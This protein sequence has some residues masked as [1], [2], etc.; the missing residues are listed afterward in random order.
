MINTPEIYTST[1]P[2]WA[3]H[4]ELVVHEPDESPIAPV[5]FSL[6]GDS[7][8]FLVATISTPNGL[9][10]PFLD[11]KLRL[12]DPRGR[13]YQQTI[14]SPEIFVSTS[15]ALVVIDNPMRGEWELSAESGIVPYAVTAMGFH[16]S[17]QSSSPPSPGP[18]GSSPFK[19]K[20]CKITAK[21]LA[22]AIVAAA[23]LQ[24]LPA[25]LIASVAAYLGVGTA[26]AI[27][28]ISS[29]LGDTADM[30]AEKLCKRV[31]LC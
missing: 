23:S 17:I 25:A 7:L 16:P 26:I 29:V 20:A 24:A 1:D 30:I 22:L 12:S 28:F 11:A 3:S 13:T 21:A 5:P 8:K 4:I 10:P 31:K 15:P 18:S 6:D 27:A 9:F 14:S 2:D 19:C